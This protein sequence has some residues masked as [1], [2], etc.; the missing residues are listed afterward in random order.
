MIRTD[1]KGK[2]QLTAECVFRFKT[3]RE[4]D[5]YALNNAVRIADVLQQRRGLWYKQ[6][7]NGWGKKIY[8]GEQK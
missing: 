6:R 2:W 1:Q 4:M 8:L 5:V 7:I 3:K